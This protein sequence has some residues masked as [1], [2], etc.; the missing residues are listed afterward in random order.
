MN[1]ASAAQLPAEVAVLAGLGPS[2]VAW[3]CL[4]M[5]AGDDVDC[6]A[7]AT[8]REVG[9]E[10]KRRSTR[11]E[12]AD[13]SDHVRAELDRPGIAAL[14]GPDALS[15]SLADVGQKYRQT[16]AGDGTGP[17][18]LARSSSDCRP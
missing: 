17:P 18:C 11:L 4:D 15:P 14:V 5:T 7:A 3:L 16:S 13:V 8:V 10:P 12:F 2:P 6:S 1:S 9:G